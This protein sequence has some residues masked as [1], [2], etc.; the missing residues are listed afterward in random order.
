DMGALWQATDAAARETA[1]APHDATAWERLGRLRMR[2]FDRAGARDA[3]ERARSLHPSEEGLLDLATI[4]HLAGDLGSEVTACEQAT[5]V[6][7]ESDRAWSRYA[8]ALARTDRPRDCLAACE[9]A[10]ALRD[11]PE[12]RDLAARARAA[13]PRALDEQAAA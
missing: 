1:V 4:A 13:T 6:A 7:P 10:L 9:R 11:D 8:H 5:H 3:L 2:R 12:V